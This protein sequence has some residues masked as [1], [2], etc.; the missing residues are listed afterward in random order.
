MWRKM[1]RERAEKSHGVTDALVPTVRLIKLNH[2]FR[3][4]PDASRLLSAE[5]VASHVKGW[6]VR[7]AC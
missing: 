5:Q 3:Q 6:S 7:V 2:A 4:F 1:K